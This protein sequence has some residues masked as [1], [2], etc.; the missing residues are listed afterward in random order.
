MSEACPA[1]DLQ[2]MKDLIRDQGK[3]AALT[4]NVAE[5]KGSIKEHHTTIITTA[6]D[7][8]HI[9]KTVDSLATG[10][11]DMNQRFSD[12]PCPA[13]T[14]LQATVTTQGTAISALNDA[15]S[16]QKGRYSIADLLV[17]GSVGAG[18]GGGIAFAIFKLLGWV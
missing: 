5:I 4:D 6:S 12:C 15:A 9:S 3:V 11:T 16:F 18:G 8:R 7:V 2:T 10:L 13:V 17:S 14:T 1:C